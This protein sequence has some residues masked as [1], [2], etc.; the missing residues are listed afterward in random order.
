[1]KT[2]FN[3]RAMRPLRLSLM[4]GAWGLWLLYS[5]ATASDVFKPDT[6]LGLPA[7][8]WAFYVPKNNPLTPAKVALGKRL[9]FETRLS[10]DGKVSCSTCHDPDRA[11]T[12]GKQVAEGVR[13]QR[14]TRNSPT[15]LNVIFNTGQFW[16]GR[17]DSLE[18][19]ATLPLI[20]P[21][22][23]GNRS[24]DDVVKRLSSSPDY[25][26]EFETAFG[27]RVTQARLALALASFERTLVSGDS[28]LDRYMAGDQRALSDD[29]R[30]GLAIFRGKG[31][32]GRCHSFSEQAPFFTDFAFHNT[33]VAANNPAF[34]E[35][36]RKVFEI[37]DKPGAP[38]VIDSLGHEPGGQELGRVLVTHH[39]F[40][41][42][43]YKT[44]SLR[45]IALTAPY[46]HDGSARTLADVVKFYNGGGQANI[47]RDGELDPLS[48]TAEEQRQLVTFLEALTGDPMVVRR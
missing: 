26:A 9:F 3:R 22:E 7:D 39:P 15:L 14:G 16:D 31:R 34:A 24:V 12:D 25:N 35:L 41:I 1:M 13:G 43:S 4:V 21:V 8:T 33:G 27:G 18:D 45:N 2:S 30:R 36:A 32:C 48:L 37:S 5:R 20:N 46:F 6:P 47:N 10:V 23:M 29:A 38:S 19:Q 44:P 11:F 42:G 40:D 28:P 17:V